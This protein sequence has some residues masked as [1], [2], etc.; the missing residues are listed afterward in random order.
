LFVVGGT[1]TILEEAGQAAHGT[2]MMTCRMMTR[3]TT[4]G[5]ER[6]VRD[7]WKPPPPLLMLLA[8]I[9]LLV[10]GSPDLEVGKH[11]AKKIVGSNL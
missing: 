8:L 6:E 1:R 9:I 7:G 11:D 10:E 2:T 4:R 5:A 3:S